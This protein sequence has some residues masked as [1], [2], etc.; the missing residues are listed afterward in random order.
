MTPRMSLQTLT[1]LR[2]MLDRFDDQHYGYD[3]MTKAKLKSG[4]LYPILDR[5]EHHGL[6]ASAWED[7]DPKVAGRAPRRYYR[8]TAEGIR[9][10]EEELRAAQASLLGERTRHA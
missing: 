10:A 7:I 6:V 4:S 3:L 8:L 2:V 1:L 5:L 9:R